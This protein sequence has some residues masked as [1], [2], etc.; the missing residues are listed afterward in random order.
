MEEKLERL[1][2]ALVEGTL[3]QGTFDA[4]KIYQMLKEADTKPE[5]SKIHEDMINVWKF[6]YT[7][8]RIK[9]LIENPGSSVIRGI[10]RGLMKEEDYFQPLTKS[11]QW[12]TENDPHYLD[13]K[14]QIEIEG[15]SKEEMMKDLKEFLSD[16]RTI[17]V[18]DWRESK[19]NPKDIAPLSKD[20]G[21]YNMF[22]SDIGLI[23]MKTSETTYSGLKICRFEDVKGVV[24]GEFAFINN[25][26]Y[27]GIAKEIGLKSVTL[28]LKSA[29]EIGKYFHDKGYDVN[30]PTLR[31]QNKYATLKFS[32]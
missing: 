4:D 13:K 9:Y 20:M 21:Q 23:T 10:E 7:R 17:E 5:R 1:E 28:D 11:L 12:Y 19:I 14:I 29:I 26:G 6:T 3:E 15:K 8:D 27:G 24:E 22:E 32:K 16:G 2:D 25:F 30:I 31:T 18:V